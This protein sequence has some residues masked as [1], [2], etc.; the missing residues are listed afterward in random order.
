VAFAS[1]RN[2]LWSGFR[3]VART[4]TSD[5][6]LG[7]T[8]TR[9]GVRLVATVNNASY[10]PVVSRWT[11]NGDTNNC[12]PNSHDAVADASG[13]MADVSRECTDV[14]VTN[15][16]DTTH[17]AV[18]RFGSGGTFAGGDPQITTS[19]GLDRMWPR[20]CCCWAAPG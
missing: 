20:A 1:E 9:H 3:N 11:G 15:L 17:A 6:N 7:L 19:P 5:A 13:R 12:S 16:P 18:V 4:W 2:G 10:F 8:D 14:A